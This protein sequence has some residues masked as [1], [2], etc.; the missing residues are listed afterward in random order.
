MPD[1]GLLVRPGWW[2][3]PMEAFRAQVEAHCH[4]CGIP[5]R[6]EGQLAQGG[7]HEE[8]S[9]THE[10]IARSKAKGR[11]LFMI[12]VTLDELVR[13]ARPST[14]YLPHSTPGY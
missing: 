5:L 6:R 14:E 13:P 1:T 8:F 11:T 10:H 4:H 3:L 9:P 12:D 2:R 7:R